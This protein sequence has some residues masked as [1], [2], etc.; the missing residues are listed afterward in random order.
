MRARFSK[1]LRIVA[2]RVLWIF[3]GRRIASQFLRCAADLV[4]IPTAAEA[5]RSFQSMLP[6]TCAGRNYRRAL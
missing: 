6:I 5:W 3:P 4:A 1:T 2:C